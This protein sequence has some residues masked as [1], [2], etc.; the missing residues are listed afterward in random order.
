MLLQSDAV[1][2]LLETNPDGLYTALEAV[3]RVM[4]TDTAA[5]VLAAGWNLYWGLAVTLTIWT[6]LKRAMSGGGWDMWEY[7]RLIVALIIPLTMLQAYDAP[8]Q[9]TSTLPITLPGS[10]APLTFPE[11]VAAQGTWLAQEINVDGMTTFWEYVRSLGYKLSDTLTLSEADE[12]ATLSLGSLLNPLA[13]P[14]LQRSIMASFAA[15]FLAFFAFV[16]AGV[17]SLIGYAQILFAQ[18]AIGVCVVLGPVMIPWLLLGP[19]SFLFWGWFRSLLTYGLYAAVSA[20]IFRVMLALLQGTTNRVLDA[21]DIG[22]ILSM[23]SAERSAAYDQATFWMVTL[24]ACSLA[25]IVS[26]LKIPS[27]AA[28]LVSGQAGGESI[29]AALGVVTGVAAVAGKAAKAAVGRAK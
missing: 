1:E 23:S 28:G 15:L 2:Q 19:M 17:A 29:G 8:L 5:P 9:L 22:Q 14:D 3:L 26:F 25:A 16:I 21:V 20:A 13:W 6:G 24:V 18:V 27:L 10:T 11:L 12:T 4:I 7:W